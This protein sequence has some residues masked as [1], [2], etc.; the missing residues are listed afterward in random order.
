MGKTELITKK[1]CGIK[2]PDIIYN[3]GISKDV[4]ERLTLSKACKGIP[5]DVFEDESFLI[6]VDLGNKGNEYC[7]FIFSVT[8]FGELLCKAVAG[9]R[10]DESKKDFDARIQYIREGL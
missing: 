8:M 7:A 10:R 6:A 1:M 2:S 3:V 5:I 4:K 9:I